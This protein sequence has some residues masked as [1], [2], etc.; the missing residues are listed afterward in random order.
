MQKTEVQRAID[1]V[2]GPAKMASLLGVTTQAVCFW[3]DGER[4]LPLDHC[5]AIQEFTGGAVTC[6]ELRP[7][8]ADYFAL[9]RAQAVAANAQSAAKFAAG[10]PAATQPQGA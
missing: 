6:E 1:I 9:I 7:D 4:K 3:R 8:K 5:P 10:L 2:G